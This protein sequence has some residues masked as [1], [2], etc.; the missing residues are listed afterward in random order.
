MSRTGLILAILAYLARPV[1]GQQLSCSGRSTRYAHSTP[2]ADDVFLEGVTDTVMGAV[3]LDSGG[4]RRVLGYLW[5]P[6]TDRTGTKV[7]LQGLHSSPWGNVIV[8]AFY[9]TQN[10]SLGGG[11][12][13]PGATAGPVL[14]LAGLHPRLPLGRPRG[15]RCE[16]AAMLGP[17]SGD[18]RRWRVAAVTRAP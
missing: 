10:G 18:A 3:D 14:W 11:V 16:P 9:D 8:T 15:R 12:K 13:R 6:F 7:E 4:F 17:G 1:A 2:F 5:L